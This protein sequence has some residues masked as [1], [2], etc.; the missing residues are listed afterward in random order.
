MR[1]HGNKPGTGM[2]AAKVL[3]WLTS[4]PGMRSTMLQVTIHFHRS[5]SV[6]TCFSTTFGS[7][8]KKRPWAIIRLERFTHLCRRTL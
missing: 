5:V 3:L 6:V 1:K 4:L 8:G 2:A 7:A